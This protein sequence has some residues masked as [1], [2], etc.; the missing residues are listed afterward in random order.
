LEDS[1][2]WLEISRGARVMDLKKWISGKKGSVWWIIPK[3]GYQLKILGEST[4]KEIIV[5]EMKEGVDG[6]K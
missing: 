2:S 4:S 5:V 6:E 1:A 3:K